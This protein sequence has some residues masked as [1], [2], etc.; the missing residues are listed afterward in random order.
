MNIAASILLRR[1]ARASSSVSVP[2]YSFRSNASVNDAI[3][4]SSSVMHI[5]LAISGNG[6][7]AKSLHD[8]NRLPFPKQYSLFNCQKHSFLFKSSHRVSSSSKSSTG[9]TG[10]TGT[11][12]GM[13]RRARRAR[14]GAECGSTHSRLR[15]PSPTNCFLCVNSMIFIWKKSKFSKNTRVWVRAVPRRN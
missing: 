2:R 1:N 14:R 13:S 3:L 7:H 12:A 10:G 4:L 9:G 11:G 8:A 15:R 6:A 5:H